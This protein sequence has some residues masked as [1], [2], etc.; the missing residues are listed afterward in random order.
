MSVNWLSPARTRQELPD[1][2]TVYFD[3]KF[4]AISSLITKPSHTALCT[5]GKDSTS[6]NCVSVRS[7]GFP[8]STCTDT[9][10]RSLP[11]GRPGAPRTLYCHGFL[12][13]FLHSPLLPGTWTLAFPKAGGLSS[14]LFLF[15]AVF[16]QIHPPLWLQIS[17]FLACGPLTQGQKVYEWTSEGPS[18]FW[19]YAKMYELMCA[20]WDKNLKCPL[21]AVCDSPH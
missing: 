15:H 13:L 10:D 2:F 11:W 14:F 6:S 4:S 9:G 8:S 1:I 5:R 20:F 12:F 19:N 18:D 7:Q 17:K 16:Q 3:M 21:K